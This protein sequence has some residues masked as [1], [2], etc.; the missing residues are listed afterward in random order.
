MILSSTL[1]AF[2]FGGMC[3]ASMRFS[4]FFSLSLGCADTRENSSCATLVS[5]HFYRFMKILA[6][7]SSSARAR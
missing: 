2:V 5:V 7:G 1:T 3:V 6:H 4:D